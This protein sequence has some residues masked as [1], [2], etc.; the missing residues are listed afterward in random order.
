LTSAIS[1]PTPEALSSFH[2]SLEHFLRSLF[3][4][5]R[6]SEKREFSF[7]FGILSDSCV[8]LW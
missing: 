1:S 2:P 5:E 6:R 8:A 4:K 3:P 7:D